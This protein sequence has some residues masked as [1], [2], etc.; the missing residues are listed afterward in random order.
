MESYVTPGTLEEKTAYWLRKIDPYN[1]HHM[2]L[3][4]E[5]SALLVIDMQYFFL[6]FLSQLMRLLSPM[7]FVNLVCM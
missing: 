3:N 5:K 6:D 1:Q 4:R 2:S 7:I